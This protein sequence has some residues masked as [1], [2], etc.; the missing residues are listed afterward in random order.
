MTDEERTRRRAEREARYS[1]VLPAA[2][3]V[4]A[5]QAQGRPTALAVGRVAREILDYAAGTDS[6][7]RFA[8]P[9][10]IAMAARIPC[11]VVAL[12]KEQVGHSEK[13]IITY[14]MFG[15]DHDEEL[16]T[17][18]LDGS[19]QG[20]VARKVWDRF[21]PDG[22]HPFVGTRMTLYKHNDAPDEKSRSSA[23]Y[24]CCVYAEPLGE[25]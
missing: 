8:L 1:E 24:R 14:R 12:R 19:E 7:G 4:A 23:G 6:R 3:Q 20:L 10:R 22:S 17:P 2:Y 21:A 18:F 13:V 25:R 16:R 9:Y 15:A 11:T 5:M